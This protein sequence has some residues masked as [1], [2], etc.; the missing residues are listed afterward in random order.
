MKSSGQ[1]LFV[2]VVLAAVLIGI[3][4]VVSQGGSDDGPSGSGDPNE[5]VERFEGIEQD[6]TVLGDPRADL[7]VTELA[8]PQCPF[9][10][11]F[12]TDAFRG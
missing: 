4:I 3:A 10:A 5:I 9:C 7:T 1:R 2:A 11:D 12:A 8:D 6:G